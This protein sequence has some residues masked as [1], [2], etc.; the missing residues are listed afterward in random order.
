MHLIDQLFFAVA[1]QLDWD[2][3]ARAFLRRHLV[4]SGLRVPDE[5]PGQDGRPPG[6]P[7]ASQG[8][9]L[10]LAALQ[11]ANDS[12]GPVFDAEVKRGLINRLYGDGSMSQEFRL[13]MVRLCRAQL[14][15][16]NEPAVT[17][18]VIAVA[19]GASPRG[20]LRGE[21]RPDLPADRPAQRP[22]HARIV[23]PLAAAVHRFIPA[24]CWS[25]ISLAGARWPSHVSSGTTASTTTRGHIRRL[26]DAA[27]A[28]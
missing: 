27:P 26:R 20:D 19:Q 14:S 25:S 28:H 4:Q 16:D 5:A 23:G 8:W 18:A 11:E 3:L 15:P 22:P 2:A 10:S 12:P 1:R 13:A 21:T 9:P 24:C 7:G 17:E 6:A